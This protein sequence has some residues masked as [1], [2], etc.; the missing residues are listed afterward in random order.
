[1]KEEGISLVGWDVFKWRL[2]QAMRNAVKAREH[3]LLLSLQN[4]E[5]RYPASK[6]ELKGLLRALVHRIR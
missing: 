1:M 4:Y 2:G 5:S 6:V 3:S